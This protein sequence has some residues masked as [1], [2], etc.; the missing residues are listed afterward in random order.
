MSKLKHNI[1]YTLLWYGDLLEK[2]YQSD[3]LSMDEIAALVGCSP[4]TVRNAILRLGIPRRRY[5]MSKGALL[6]RK[7]G[8]IILHKK[9]KRK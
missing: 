8:G 1:K 5:T 3:K 4:N 6:A 2:M 7:M 9:E